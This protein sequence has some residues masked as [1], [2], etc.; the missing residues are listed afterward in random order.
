MSNN[1]Q[2][3]NLNELLKA[4]GYDEDA[5]GESAAVPPYFA[6]VTKTHLTQNNI[7]PK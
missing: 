1:E 2:S 5:E 6:E 7:L 3:N 4:G